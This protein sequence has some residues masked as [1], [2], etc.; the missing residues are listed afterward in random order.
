ME[1]TTENTRAIIENM[2]LDGETS[3]ADYVA[4]MQKRI[5]LLGSLLLCLVN[6]T[7]HSKKCSYYLNN[8]KELCNCGYDDAKK[9]LG[10][11]D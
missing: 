3:R 9:A 6:N 8:G 2:R 1:V 4:L 7:W 5:D 11:T 10:I